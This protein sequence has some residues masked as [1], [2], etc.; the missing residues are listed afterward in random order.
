MTSAA[1]RARA[2]PTAVNPSIPMPLTNTR[3]PRRSPAASH[4]AITVATAHPAVAATPSGSESGTGTTATP[5][6]RWI[7]LA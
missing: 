4:I 3:R 2:A 7:W 1:P 6:G 5:A